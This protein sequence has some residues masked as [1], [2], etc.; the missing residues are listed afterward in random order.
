LDVVPSR[1]GGTIDL[2]V[3]MQNE[4]QKLETGGDRLTHYELLDIGPDADGGAVRRAYLE[5][6]KR[7]HPDA[8]FRRELGPYG[9]LLSKWF[10]RLSSAYQVLCD[11]DLRAV[12]DHDHRAQ[13]SQRHPAALERRELSRA[14]EERRARER[15]ERLLRTK[16]F[17]RIGAARRLY[18]E[19]IEHALNG[20]RTQA[21][22]ALKAARELD[23]NRKEIGAK[24]V[25]LEREQAKARFRSALA[26]AK[27]REEG[28]KFAEA[29]AGYAAAFQN[30]PTSFEAAMGATRCTLE[31][32]DTRAATTWA[33]RA[34]QLNPDDSEARLLFVR[35]LLGAGMKVRARNEL[36]TLLDKNP[37]HK[38]AKA[39][40]KAL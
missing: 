5:R 38:E 24:M 4:L 26:S 28:R 35:L 13:L 39:L 8:W 22:Y 23:P 33:T 31:M 20:E 7:F 17:A 21:I 37:D 6:S 27:E 16:G 36:A 2:P 14:D 30:D 32:S 19:A 18:E 29:I 40:L 25:E 15:R 9:P 10:K 11:E 1:P 34:V 3:D 12:Y